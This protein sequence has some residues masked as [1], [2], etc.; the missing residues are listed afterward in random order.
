[1][2]FW[3]RLLSFGLPETNR[4]ARDSLR[5]DARNE[6]GENKVN[7]VEEEV[8]V[9]VVKEIEEVKMEKVKMGVVE[10]VEK[11]KVEEGEAGPEGGSATKPA[12]QGSSGV[13]K[14]REERAI[15]KVIIF[16]VEFYVQCMS[17]VITHAMHIQSDPSCNAC[18]K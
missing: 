16:L 9:G 1:M 12:N 3:L 10:E 5:V 17:K 2:I 15:E 8:E 6:Q 14:K 18:P 7:E 4:T 11:V 13:T